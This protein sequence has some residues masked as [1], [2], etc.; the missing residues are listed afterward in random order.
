MVLTELGMISVIC[1]NLSFFI[2]ISAFKFST[3]ILCSYGSHAA[4]TFEEKCRVLQLLLSC[5]RLG[6]CE[7]A[8]H[9]LE[10]TLCPGCTILDTVVA[11]HA[12]EFHHC[13]A[14]L[15]QITLPHHGLTSARQ[16]K[17]DCM[18]YSSSSRAILFQ[19]ALLECQRQLSESGRAVS[20]LF[21]PR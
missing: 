11:P 1:Q 12:G 6:P 10:F 20:W 15:C 3:L 2:P 9:L 8:I 16:R 21:A 14:I 18:A 4:A 19:L 17:R 7:S 5:F 13:T